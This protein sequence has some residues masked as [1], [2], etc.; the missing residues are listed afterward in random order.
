MNETKL[1]FHLL[2]GLNLHLKGMQRTKIYVVTLLKLEVYEDA[3][4][5]LSP[6][7]LLS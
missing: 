7:F 1:V 6:S 3:F 2:P 5:W 4:I